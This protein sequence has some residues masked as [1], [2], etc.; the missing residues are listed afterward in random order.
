MA[1]I[2]WLGHACVR[3]KTRD[4][5]V[6]M[7]PAG[8]AAGVNLARQRADIVT[9][10]RRGGDPAILASVEG[11]YTLVDGPGDYEVSDIFVTGIRT[12]VNGTHGA[13]GA[14][15][16]NTVYLVEMDEI[17]FCH[18]G[19]LRDTLAPAQVEVLGDPDVLFVP[20]GEPD[21][22]PTA[23]ATEIIGQLTPKMVIPIGYRMG[24]E[25]GLR[26]LND[27]VAALGFTDVPH[28]TSLV[29]RKGNLPETMGLTVLD[30]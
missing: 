24:D 22:L 4:V 2:K 17:V 9:L 11:D 16:F 20:I 23:K 12:G 18:L 6:L 1:D 25:A 13:N 14:K 8:R 3:V 15:E 10:S 7:D 26:A 28:G 5:T 27:L 30:V 21:G 19:G 29:L